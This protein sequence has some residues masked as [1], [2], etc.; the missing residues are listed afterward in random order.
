MKKLLAALFIAG[1]LSSCT[2][3]DYVT[4]VAPSQ[5]LIPIQ[6]IYSGTTPTNVYAD[7]QV[8]FL[9]VS[10]YPSDTFYVRDSARLA[11]YIQ[12]Q[13]ARDTIALPGLIWTIQ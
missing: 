7:S 9:S 6:L 5:Q 13:P 1:L 3:T 4:Q 11:V 12:G 2:K 10:W 8:I